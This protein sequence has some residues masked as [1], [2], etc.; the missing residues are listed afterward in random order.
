MIRQF[1]S[2]RGNLFGCDGT[3]AVPPVA[4]LVRKNVGNFLVGQCFVPGL[5]HRRA[6]LLA[7]NFD[8]ALQTFEDN[9]SRATRAACCKLCTRKRWILAAHT[10]AVGL[11]TGLTLRCETR[12]PT[13]VR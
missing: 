5:H 3:G 2:E 1:F 7:F 9:H 13:I 4:S 11:M 8:R 12:A 6:V 10:E